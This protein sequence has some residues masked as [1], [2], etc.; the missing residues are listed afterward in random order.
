M[1]LSGA[2]VSDPARLKPTGDMAASSSRMVEGEPLLDRCC[3]YSLETS[4]PLT[5]VNRYLRLRSGGLSFDQENIYFFQPALAP[6]NP[7]SP[8]PTRPRPLLL[9][10]RTGEPFRDHQTSPAIN[11]RS[12]LYSVRYCTTVPSTLWLCVGILTIYM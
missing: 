12:V 5:E 8:P 2:L 4:Q 9:S 1:C 7:P 11:T 6:S 10:G 3:V